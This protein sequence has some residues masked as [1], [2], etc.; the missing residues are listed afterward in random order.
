MGLVL[1]SLGVGTYLG[2]EDAATDSG[3]EAS[4]AVAL[5]AAVNVF[6][7]AI[8]YR[9]QKS[10]RA[11]GRALARAFASGA[12]RR[13]EVLVSTKG[14]YLP[15]DA[16]D[17]RPP[18]RYLRET[19]LESGLAPEDAIAQ[20]CHCLTPAYLRDQIARSRVEPR[21]RHDRPL[22]PAQRRDAARRGGPGGISRERLDAAIEVLEGEV[23]A[24]RIAAWGL[25]TWDGLRVPSE[26]PEHLSLEEVLDVAREV[27][28][29]GHH[30]GAVQLPTNLAMAAERGVSVPGERSGLRE[31]G[32]DG[33][34]GP[35]PG[36]VRVG[37]AAPGAAR[38]LRASPRTCARRFPGRRRPLL[39]A[40]QFA[41]SAPGVTTALVGVSDPEHAAEDFALAR[42]PP[43]DSAD[44]SSA[45]SPK[46]LGRGLCGG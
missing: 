23:G 29:P 26:H 36:G 20:G 35:R 30:F 5:G 44:V 24:G 46:V 7:S 10:E 19:F 15:H 31:P 28:G 16:D 1:S 12:A 6:D 34:E 4:V 13:D 21:A 18:R 37:L 32:L 39:Q 14:G 45:S 42:V 38:R 17:P 27:A 43:A 3:Y 40:L 9:G 41:R 33:R 11:I 25:A 2:D 8:N 22:L